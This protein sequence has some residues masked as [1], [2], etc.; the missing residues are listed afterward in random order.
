MVDAEVLVALFD[1]ALHVGACGA[2]DPAG[3]LEPI[4]VFNLDV[5]AAGVFNV[6]LFLIQ[7]ENLRFLRTW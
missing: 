2:D 4:L 6:L 5:V 3:H 7:L 1:Y